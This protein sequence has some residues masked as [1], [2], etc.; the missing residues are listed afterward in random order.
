MYK[1]FF[2]NNPLLAYPLFSLTLF[3][4]MFLV[5]VL[6]VW[7]RARVLEARAVALLDQDEELIGARSLGGSR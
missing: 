5:V 2:A 7:G 6:G 4:S 3:G 1:D